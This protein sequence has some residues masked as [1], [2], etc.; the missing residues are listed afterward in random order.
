MP[1][2]PQ[3]LLEMVLQLFRIVLL[4][5]GS[6][7][8]STLGARN[9]QGAEEVAFLTVRA[10]PAGR[11]HV[12]EQRCWSSERA[13]CKPALSQQ[14]WAPAAREHSSCFLLEKARGW[15]GTARGCTLSSRPHTASVS[16]AWTL[17]LSPSCPHPTTGAAAAP[18]TPQ[19]PPQ[20]MC[21]CTAPHAP[22]NHP[23]DALAA[24]W[25]CQGSGRP[26]RGSQGC[27]QEAGLTAG[28][29]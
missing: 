23:E 27:W 17:G 11:G 7:I 9:R 10:K 16:P 25:A 21:G 6:G 1:E 20:L 18:N 28:L 12:R 4:V 3:S 29:A 15:V 13:A 24:S 2:V 8:M 22:Q 5:T 26:A 19:T 14:C